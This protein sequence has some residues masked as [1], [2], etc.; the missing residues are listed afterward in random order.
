MQD[1]TIS[2]G[3]LTIGDGSVPAVNFTT[4]DLMSMPDIRSADVELIQRDGLWPGN[5]Y[6]GARTLSLSLEVQALTVAEFN[7]AVNLV[8]RAFSPG[9]S[10]ESPLSFRIPGLC[11]G[12]PAY[13]NARTRKRS[14][15]LDANFARLF[16]AFEVELVA[17]DP[18]AYAVDESAVTLRA[19]VTSRIKVQGSCPAQTTA[20]FAGVTNPEISNNV[21]STVFRSPG[22]GT[23]TV[24]GPQLDPGERYLRLAGTTG[25]AVLTWRDTWW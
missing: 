12:V 3:P 10:G 8:C 2:Y 15:P 22:S 9:V 16:C 13:Y 4:V 23:R 5:D 24:P 18:L 6:M 11:G 1:F 17:T 14:Q 20:A 21:D 19:G 25:T 7:E